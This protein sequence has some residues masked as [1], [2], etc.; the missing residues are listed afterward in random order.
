VAKDLV[1]Q[2]E[3]GVVVDA[4]DSVLQRPIPHGARAWMA[5]PARLL[6]VVRV[7]RTGSYDSRLERALTIFE[8]E[9]GRDSINTAWVLHLAVVLQL[10]GALDG[11]R[12]RYKRAL[13]FRKS[14]LGVNH[15][16]RD[17]GVGL[18]ARLAL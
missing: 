15:P 12:R 2:P 5:R 13:T 14:Y 11:A 4:G 6:A 17:L 16:E 1:V 3:L 8:A 7:H 18:T 9:A 10:Q